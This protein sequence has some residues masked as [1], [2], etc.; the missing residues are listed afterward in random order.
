MVV[1]GWGIILSLQSGSDDLVVVCGYFVR[2][3]LHLLV[4]WS[5]CS[6]IPLAG[7]LL[8]DWVLPDCPGRSTANWHAFGMLLTGF[9]DL[10]VD[11]GSGRESHPAFFIAG[12]GED[13]A[14]GNDG[15]RRRGSLGALDA[16]FY[17]IFPLI[18]GALFK[19]ID[20][21]VM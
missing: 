7:L 12:D 10:F 18:M 11:S 9:E 5:W 20:V 13:L 21:T 3:V 6:L 19:G 1:G 2:F 14:C 17:V 15:R 4:F 16:V 8:V